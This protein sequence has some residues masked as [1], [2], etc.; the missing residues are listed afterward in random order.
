MTVF[1]NFT[2]L[3]SFCC[4]SVGK[5]KPCLWLFLSEAYRKGAYT[6]GLVAYFSFYAGNDA[7]YYGLF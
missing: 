7:N 5:I 6:F 4:Y 2:A 1:P 3:S